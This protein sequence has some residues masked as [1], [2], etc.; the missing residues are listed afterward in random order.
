MDA[1]AFNG[2]FDDIP[3]IGELPTD[4]VVE[5]LRDIGARDD[6]DAVLRGVPNTHESFGALSVGDRFFVWRHRS[7]CFGFI[8]TIDDPAAKQL[9]IIHPGRIQ[10][11]EALKNA[12]IVVTLDRLRVGSYPGFGQHQI[13][14]EFYGQHQVPKKTEDLHFNLRFEAR[15][16]DD[17]AYIGYPIFV[18]LNVGTQGVNFDC[19]TINVNNDVDEAFIK[20]LDSDVFKSGLKLATTAQPAI[21]PFSAMAI[22]LTRSIAQGNR[23]KVVQKFSLGLDFSNVAT[24]ARLAIGSYVAVQVPSSRLADWDWTMWKYNVDRAQ[25]L[26]NNGELIP[27][28]YLVFGVSRYEER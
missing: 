16:G 18:G 3:S 7:H 24:R 13:M 28:N 4:A 17:A 27:F 14:F 25:I 10:P 15:D 23:N 26:D 20:F 22:G 12:R 21:A 6:A 19:L 11:V 5:H 2:A 8:P 1:S 9:D